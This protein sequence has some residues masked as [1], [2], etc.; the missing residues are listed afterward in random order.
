MSARPTSS[1]SVLGNLRRSIAVQAARLIAEE[2]IDDFAFA[3][4]KAARQLGVPERDLPTNAEVEEELATWRRLYRDEDDDE[5]LTQM[6]AAALGVMRQFASFRPYVTGAV[7]DGLGD[8]FSEL[9]LEIYAD[10]AKDVEIF[11][12]GLA[13]DYEHSEVRRT[14]H[15]APEAILVFDWGEVPVKLTIYSHLAERSPHRSHAGT[16]QE[17]MRLEAFEAM[18]G[19]T[20]DAPE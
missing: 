6:R 15:D 18:L 20:A 14:G 13:L 16:V 8:A 7:V 4:R 1:D 9:E 10:S 19:N 2:G 3:K 11:L 17:R 5:R 12:L